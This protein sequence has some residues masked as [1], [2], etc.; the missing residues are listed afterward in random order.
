M[1]QT[2]C[3]HVQCV[4][5]LKVEKCNYASVANSPLAV[6]K[7]PCKTCNNAFSF[8]LFLKMKLYTTQHILEQLDSVTIVILLAPRRW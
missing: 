1:C 7:N 8:F 4:N 2:C 3:L 5:M 6:F